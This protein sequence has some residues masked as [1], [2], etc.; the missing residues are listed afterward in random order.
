VTDR[1]GNPVRHPIK[2]YDFQERPRFYQSKEKGEWIEPV[3]GNPMGKSN[4][5]IKNS[6]GNSRMLDDLLRLIPNHSDK[7]SFMKQKQII[8]NM[9]KRQRRW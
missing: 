1:N 9:R 7:N 4:N 8:M 2:M 6:H 3:D 5:E